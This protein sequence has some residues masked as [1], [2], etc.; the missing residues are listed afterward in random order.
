[1]LNKKKL[2]KRIEVGILLIIFG[3]TI[4]IIPSYYKAKKNTKFLE[5]ALGTRFGIAHFSA[6]GN[7]N[8]PKPNYDPYLIEKFKDK[9]LESE[10]KILIEYILDLI[11]YQQGQ[12]ED[13]QIK[14]LDDKLLLRPRDEDIIEKIW[15]EGINAEKLTLFTKERKKVTFWQSII[16]YTNFLVLFSIFASCLGVIIAHKVKNNKFVTMSEFFLIV[17]TV[18]TCFTSG[19]HLISTVPDFADEIP[20]FDLAIFGLGPIAVIW[21]SI[22]GIIDL[23]Y[24]DI[25]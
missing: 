8:S 3:I 11:E 17:I 1:M 20:T 7:F 16:Q 23:L 22:K 12:I 4:F 2:S 15:T 24:P 21:L 13:Y 5:L 9:Y 25:A 14:V 10:D 18:S 19:N 6:H